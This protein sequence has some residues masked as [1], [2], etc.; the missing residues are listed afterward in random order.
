MVIITIFMMTA[1][2]E[3]KHG[4]SAMVNP[5]EEARQGGCDN[6]KVHVCVLE[7]GGQPCSVSYA[8]VDCEHVIMDSGNGANLH[9]LTQDPS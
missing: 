7:F 9:P 3:G 8:G 1:A 4:R 6:W 2:K 5:L